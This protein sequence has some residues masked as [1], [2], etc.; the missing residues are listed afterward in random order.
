MKGSKT[1]SKSVRP[2]D[3]VGP[4]VFASSGN[5]FADMRLP[6]ADE[7]R[8]KAQLAHEICALIRR[9]NLTQAK[10][11]RKLGIDQPKVS[12]L[13]RGRLKTFST[14]RLLRFITLLDRDVW[15][16][17][18]EPKRSGPAGMRVLAEA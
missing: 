2:D 9:A 14:D 11:A 13:M 10:A 4:F 17:I 16:V 15:I 1:K 18:R 5:V 6:D 7:R 8:A 12:A 3:V